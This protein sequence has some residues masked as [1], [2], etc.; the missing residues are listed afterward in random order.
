[1][2]LIL[3]IETSTELCSVAISQD[4]VC[5]S[6]SSSAIPNSHTEMLTILIQQ[7][8]DQSCISFKQLD[9]VALSSGPGSY[10]SLR[11]GASTVKGICF[12]MNLPLITIDS[13]KILAHGI[14]V[15]QLGAD[16]VII[17]MIDARRMEV[18]ATVFNKSLQPIQPIEAVILDDS[19]YKEY[20]SKV[21]ICGSGAKKF[22][23][24]F[25]HSNL[26]LHH[27]YTSAKFM[28]LPS[29]EAYANRQFSDV[30]Y[31]SPEYIKAPNIVKS[32]KKYF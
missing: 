11:V 8:L 22:I 7:C 10:T 1:M 30:A 3:Q 5:V 29:T 17:P 14:N 13:L 21:H 26:I 20:P 16:D 32:E 4:G 28:T 2:A 25:E 27:E 31:F 15:D 9:A 12:A 24:A 6:Q 19:T 23:D 18:Y